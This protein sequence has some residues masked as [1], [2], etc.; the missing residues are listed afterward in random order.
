MKKLMG[1]G[2]RTALRA[3][4]AEPRVI[5]VFGNARLVKRADGRHELLGGT[6]ADHAEA[7]EWCTLFAPEVVF[8]P[9]SRAP[10]LIHLAA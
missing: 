7:R 2:T 8:P 9:A 10:R 1:L 6:A 5:A 3:L 4:A